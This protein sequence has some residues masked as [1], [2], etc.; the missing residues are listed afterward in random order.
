MFQKTNDIFELLFEAISEGVLVVDKH[1]KIIAINSS[2]EMMFGYKKSEVINAS[3]NLFIPNK[4][5]NKHKSHFSNYYQKSS[6]RQMS[7]ENGLFGKRKND[8]IFPLEVGLNPF[9]INGEKYVMALVVDIS[10]RKK[11]EQEIISL[12]SKLEE[13][14]QDRTTALNES[15][16]K[17]K[18][19]N[20]DL[21]FEIKKRIEAE[22]KIKIALKREKELNEL[23]TNFLSLVSHEF[24]TPLS[25]I[26]SSTQLLGKYTLTEQQEKR[27]KHLGIIKSKVYYLNN[28]LND[29]LSIEKLDLGKVNYQIEEINLNETI[30]KVIDDLNPFLKHGQFINFSASEEDIIITSDNKTLE[31]ILANVVNN[32]IKYSP[33]HGKIRLNLTRENSTAIFTVQD[34][35]IGIPKKEQKYI[36]NRYFRA[37]NALL[38]EGTGIG[39]NIVKSHL[40]NL[41]GDIAF[42]S[43]KE[44][45]TIFTLTFPALTI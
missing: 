42:V 27:E 43:D 1:Q 10:E 30:K 23:K 25:G 17:L 44:I 20:L 5:H 34:N 32:A 45:G 4:Y 19:L 28:I 2:I 12:N 24:K 3:L 16:A 38:N 13:K 15:V 26:L 22:K 21:E 11:I 36:F 14:I 8:E 33:E 39:L 6:K 35:G 31:L 9:E 40:E 7:S 18:E 41:N 29:F 37:E